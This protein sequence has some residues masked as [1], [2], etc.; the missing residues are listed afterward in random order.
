MVERKHRVGIG[1]PVYN[2]ERYLREALDAL[3]AQTF[4]DFELVIC[5]NASTDG[6]PEISQAYAAQDQRIRYIR[7]DVN[8]G[9]SRNFNRAFELSSGEYFRWATHDDLCAPEYLERCVDALDGDPSLVLC[10]SATRE[11]DEDGTVTRDYATKPGLGS[12]KPHERLYECICVPHP[13][14][15]VFGLIRRAELA[16]THLIGSYSSSDRV[17]LGE[18]ALVG[19][20][21]QVPEP[22]FSRRDHPQQSYKAYR[23]RREYQAWF[24]PRRAGKITFPHWRLLYEYAT[25]I[26]RARLGISDRVRCYM[27]LGW[28]IRLNWRYLASNLILREPRR[29]P[30]SRLVHAEVEGG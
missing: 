5:D 25:A 30:K 17:L 21:H 8:L 15:L 13:Q 27:V 14:V 22:L 24:D 19:R 20:L 9:A 10:H 3:R 2:G 4:T 7:N 23:T 29:R 6:T 26:A 28:W 1:L 18:L 16:R 11:I 12:P